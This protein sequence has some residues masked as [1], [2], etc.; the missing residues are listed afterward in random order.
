MNAGATVRREQTVALVLNWRDDASTLRCVVDLCDVFAQENVLVVDNE[1]RGTMVEVLATHGLGE[2]AVMALPENRGFAGGV[3]AGLAHILT[4]GADYI[5]VINSD[6]KL[7]LGRLSPIFWDTH[8]P[9]DVGAVGPVIL[10]PDGTVQSAGGRVVAWT[11]TVADNINGS[12]AA[13][14]H[15]L[16]WACVM[17]RS[18]AVRDVGLLDE[19]FFMYWEDVDFGLRLR[20][21]GYRLAVAAEANIVHLGSGSH[22]RAGAR[23]DRYHA[24]GAVA[25][26]RKYGGWWALGAAM[27]IAA[28]IAR[29]ILGGR[30]AAA[31]A[32]AEGAA[33]GLRGKGPAYEQRGV[34]R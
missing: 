20:A 6:T 32:V 28:R 24:L 23:I 4:V 15:Y 13:D 34:T 21:K 31:A 25:L 9:R 12:S 17:L 26:G 7:D 22:P 1:S 27:R 14:I 18:S 16:T 8:W 33:R 5:F 29:R 30:W 19:R 2:V 11:L 3:N 10:N